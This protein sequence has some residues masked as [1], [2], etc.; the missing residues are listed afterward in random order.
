MNRGF[1]RLQEVEMRKLRMLVPSAT[2]LSLLVGCQGNE[3]TAELEVMKARAEVEEQNK[4]LIRQYY[5]E[6]DDTDIGE[7]GEFVARFVSPEFILH[8]PGG[9]DVSGMEALAEYYTGMSE[10]FPEATHTI[11]DVI[12]EGD[13]VA[14][15]ATTRG[16]H[17]GEFMGIRPT[18]NEVT[19]TFDGFC[20]IRDGKIVEWWSEYDALG[21]MTQL[22]MRLTPSAGER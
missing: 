11:D 8:L 15:R 22:G 20:R 1:D 14:F 13:K 12:A 18:G 7:L 6:L 3:A 21:L 19:I 16:I 10:A 17:R 5:V 9:V 4:E 2:I